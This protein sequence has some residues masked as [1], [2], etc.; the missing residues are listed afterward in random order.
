VNRLCEKRLHQSLLCRSIAL[1]I[2]SGWLVSP[3]IGDDRASI[4]RSDA[5]KAEIEK[6]SILISKKPDDVRA[7]SRRGDAHFFHG[8]FD[9]ALADY[10]KMVELE[11]A[12]DASHWRRGIALFYAGKYEQAASQFERYHSFDNVDRENGIWRYLCQVKAYGVK[13]AESDLL[14]YEKDDREPFGDV[15]RLFAGTTEPDEILTKIASA[16][17]EGAERDKRLFYAQLY[18]GLWHA[19]HNRPESAK[20]HL[21]SASENGWPQEAGYGPNYMW[22]VGRLHHQ[23]LTT[24]D[25]AERDST[26]GS[27]E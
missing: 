1:A 23:L 10:D 21:K 5:L 18:I 7:Y 15:Y 11:P 3:A 27:N 4:S 6:L 16:G 17:V 2:L 13:R 22:H 12:Q 20:P 24:V 9:Q 14:K 26:E 8:Q 19:V 25:R